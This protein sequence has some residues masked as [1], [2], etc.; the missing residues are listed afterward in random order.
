MGSRPLGIT[1]IAI[2]L[3]VGGIAQILTGTEAVG[4]TSLGLGNVTGASNTVGWASVITG[5]LTIIVS[6]GLFTLSG[7][8]WWLTVLVMGARIVTDVIAIA[9]HG[10]SSTLGIAAVTNL[11]ISGLVLLYFNSGGVRR[12][13]GK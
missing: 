13:F 12:A 4:V 7:W 8:A 6:A 11:V 2:V 10:V 3:L 1:I 9:T 5:V